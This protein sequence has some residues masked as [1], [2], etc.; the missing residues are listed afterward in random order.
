MG[1]EDYTL[2]CLRKIIILN[3]EVNRKMEL[4]NE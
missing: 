1:T 2:F 3:L 4:F